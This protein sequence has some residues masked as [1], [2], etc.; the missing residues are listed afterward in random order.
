MAT[1]DI[2]AK[3]EIAKS[4]LEAEGIRAVISNEYLVGMYWLWSNAF[5]G[6]PVQVLEED[7]EQAT[8]VLADRFDP[9]ELSEE[10]CEEEST[11]Q[12]PAAVPEPDEP[13]IRGEQSPPHEAPDQPDDPDS[14]ERYSWWAFVFSYYAGVFPPFAVYALYLYFNA[15]MGQGPVSKLG[16]IGLIAV[17]VIVLPYAI[18]AA[19]F[20]RAFLVYGSL[21]Y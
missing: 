8:I 16:Q 13:E 20:F 7:V 1:S 3:A 19:L 12:T 21:K 5:G 15:V 2:A 14:R 11:R 17:G 6:I 18:L 9:G 4:L 10:S